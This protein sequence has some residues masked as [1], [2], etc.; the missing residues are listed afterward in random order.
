MWLMIADGDGAQLQETTSTTL[1]LAGV[2]VFVAEDEFLLAL[3]LC[4]IL[5]RAGAEV[6]GPARSRAEAESYVTGQFAPELALLDLNLGGESSVG[7]ALKLEAL[8]IP[9]ILTTGYDAGDL[10]EP[11]SAM[12]ICMKPISAVAVLRMI[13]RVLGRVT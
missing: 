5:A 2:R 3:D 7:I 8:G 1:P 4:D 13:E 12:P 11:L 9:V 6:L 10:P